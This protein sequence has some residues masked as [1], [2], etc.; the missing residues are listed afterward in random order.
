M[1]AQTQINLLNSGATF[2]SPYFNARPYFVHSGWVHLN[3][4]GLRYVGLDGY[5]WSRA[6]KT[7]SSPTSAY[8]YYLDFDPSGVTPSSNDIRWYGFPVRCLV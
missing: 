7:Y 4:S 2:M 3:I 5:G 1:L 6:A 8:A